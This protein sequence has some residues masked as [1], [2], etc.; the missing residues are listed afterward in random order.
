MASWPA[1]LFLLFLCLVLLAA[2]ATPQSTLPPSVDSADRWVRPRCQSKCGNVSIPYPFG[3]DDGC[4]RTGFEINCTNGTAYLGLNLNLSSNMEV[5]DI[6][7]LQG[8]LGVN[9]D[10]ARDCYNSTDRSQSSHNETLINILGLKNYKF[11]SDQNRFV[12]VGCDALGY[13]WSQSED[14]WT[15]CMSFW[16]NASLVPNDTCSGIG[17]CTALIPIDLRNFSLLVES[18]YNHSFCMDTPCSYAFLADLSKLNFNLSNL[19]EYTSREKAP[20]TLDWVITKQTC[21]E[22][23]GNDGFACVSPNSY[24]LNSTNGPGYLC[25]CSKGFLGNPYLNDSNGCSDLFAKS[26][27]TSTS[28]QLFLRHVS[29]G[30]I[31]ERGAILALAHGAGFSLFFLIAIVSWLYWIYKKRELGELKQHFFEK[32]GGSL[33]QDIRLFSSEELEAASDNYNQSRILGEGG[34]GTVY[35]GVLPNQNA[36]A[37]KKA[38]IS[39]DE[40]EV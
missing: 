25:N 8:T 7:L 27:Q 36:I 10:I 3:I 9:N 24:C 20:A 1:H 35:R 15:G 12:A 14:F 23:K 31:I 11:S 40:A 18:Y 19:T 34:T 17:C 33:R 22:A 29:N 38:K 37:I 21:E 39:N 16:T 32:N 28:A 4:F 6:Q 2:R 30:A 5:V 13:V 26:D